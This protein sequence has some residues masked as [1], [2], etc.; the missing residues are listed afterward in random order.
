MVNKTTEEIFSL[1]A[2]IKDPEIPVLTIEELGVLRKVEKQEGKYI[3]YITPTYSGCPAMK[4]FEEEISSVLQQN[5]ITHFEIKTIYSPAWTTDWLSPQARE[6][7][8]QYGI[9]PPEG[10]PDKNLLKGNPVSV[11]C[12]R[13]GRKNT[14]M[15]S[16]FGSTACKA[17]YKCNDC[18]DPFE[19]FKCL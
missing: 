12:P 5:G 9:A 18:N 14:E 11:T 17:L 10:S 2:G 16:A 13:C 4:L 15:I 3:I 1:L 7:L 19:Y 6:K 8:K